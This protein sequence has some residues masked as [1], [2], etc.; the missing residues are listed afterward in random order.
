MYHLVTK[1]GKE[2]FDYKESQL[3]SESI[4]VLKLGLDYDT[5]R[6]KLAQSKNFEKGYCVRKKRIPLMFTKGVIYYFDYNILIFWDNIPNQALL[7]SLIDNKR[8]NLV[9]CIKTIEDADPDEMKEKSYV[10]PGYTE[11][12]IDS[13]VVRF[14]DI[15]FL[16]NT[17]RLIH[18]PRV[19]MLYPKDHIM[20]RYFKYASEPSV[21]VDLSKDIFDYLLKNILQVQ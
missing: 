1:L 8:L 15:Y 20:K 11:E 4:I 3:I 5:W 10:E 14:A 7:S 12:E 17:L 2:Y 19:V 13:Q 16:K 21:V 6:N 18:R 9:F